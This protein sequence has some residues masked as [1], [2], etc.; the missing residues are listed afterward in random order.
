M[1]ENKKIKTIIFVSESI[2]T[3]LGATTIFLLQFF[4]IPQ[5]I[6]FVI[7]FV[8]VLTIYL[9]A[10]H[11]CRKMRKRVFFIGIL[12][13]FI[14]VIFFISKYKT[15]QHSSIR[16]RIISSSNVIQE[17]ISENIINPI[18][19]YLSNKEYFFESNCVKVIVELENRRTYPVSIRDIKI[20]A[21]MSLGK[22]QNLLLSDAYAIFTDGE[23]L[24][25]SVIT[26][27]PYEIVRKEICFVFSG[28]PNNKNVQD[29]REYVCH[30][31]NF[32]I[33][34][35]DVFHGIGE[36]DA[37]LD[38]KDFALNYENKKYKIETS[39]GNWM[40]GFNGEPSSPDETRKKINQHF[41]KIK[42][43]PVGYY[44]SLN[45]QQKQSA[46]REPEIN[47]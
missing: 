25:N 10:L 46:I 33:V 35:E 36:S 27:P 37:F 29:D 23:K 31:N 5:W 1:F 15:G 40:Y 38:K 22:A 42:K 47:K 7:S 30:L 26:V 8:I 16:C 28:L 34:Y 24:S 21:N 19:Y 39:P 41:E 20:V 12:T 13:L 6:P 17:K 3:I 9:I 14:F 11:F 45:S 4:G 32:K 2:I 44:E 18:I 43:D